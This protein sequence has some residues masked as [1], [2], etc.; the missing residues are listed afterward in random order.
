MAKKQTDG[1]TSEPQEP[2]VVPGPVAPEPKPADPEPFTMPEELRDK[3]QEE[4]AKMLQETKKK[5]GEQGK[6]FGERAKTLEDKIAGLEAYRQQTEDERRM[7]EM[8]NQPQP[9]QPQYQPQPE[10]KPTFDYERPLASIESYLQQREKQQA[11]QNQAIV[12]QKTINE[13]KFAFQQGRTLAYRD[14]PELYRGI[15]RDVEQ[16]VYQTYAPFANQGVAVDKFVGDPSIWR[17]VAQNVRI[18][19]EEYDYLRP[20]KQPPIRPTPSD[21]PNPA[22]RQT[23]ELPG[24]YELDTNSPDIVALEKAIRVEGGI[25]VSPEERKKILKAEQDRLF[26][27][28]RW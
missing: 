15:E 24:Q 3:S 19:R 22:Q 27:G 23:Q 12:R 11:T 20:K 8:Y 9:Q 26:K 14:D 5:L 25:E 1:I 6:D 10:D 17:K 28:Q 21:V 13:G 18:E 16:R 4:L 2:Q 7:Y